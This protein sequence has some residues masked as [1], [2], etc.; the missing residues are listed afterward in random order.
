MKKSARSRGAK[1]QDS[2]LLINV[3]R[4]IGSTLGTVTRKAAAMA[5]E[6]GSSA[7]RPSMAA[8]KPSRKAGSKVLRKTGVR[9]MK[10]SKK[11]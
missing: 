3:A 8:S 4:T 6:L 11:K 9:R 1:K 2:E 7:K 10:S 5:K